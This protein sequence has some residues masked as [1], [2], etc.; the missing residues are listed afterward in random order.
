ME[1]EKGQAGRLCS[2][3]SGQTVKRS[4]TGRGQVTGSISSGMQAALVD[5]SSWEW[6][7]LWRSLTGDNW[8]PLEA[9]GRIGDMS[10]EK[11]RFPLIFETLR[12]FRTYRHLPQVIHS[13]K[14]IPSFYHIPVY[15]SCA[16]P[17]ILSQLGVRSAERRIKG[18]FGEED[19]GSYKMKALDCFSLLLLFYWRRYLWSQETPKHWDNPSATWRPQR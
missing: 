3:Q 5:S 7:G 8:I 9:S 2:H 14:S 17:W 12:K 16:G 6:S 10:S 15:R 1:A 4:K 11:A 19:G 13:Q 18:Y